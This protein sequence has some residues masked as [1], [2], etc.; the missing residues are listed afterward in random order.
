MKQETEYHVSYNL[1][2][3]SRIF[4]LIKNKIDWSTIKI[5][6]PPV[7][8]HEMNTAA[9]MIKRDEIYARQLQAE[10]NHEMNNTSLRRKR[11]SARNRASPVVETTTH[12]APLEI[13]QDRGCQKD[14]GHRCDLVFTRRCC[15]CS[16]K[17]IVMADFHS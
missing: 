10:L 8:H 12:V 17:I 5:S 16:G 3:A 14:C 6:S 11:A 1:E 13:N 2:E 4:Q 15:S 9:T 7:T